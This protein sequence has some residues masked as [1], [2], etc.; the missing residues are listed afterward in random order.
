MHALKHAKCARD[1]LQWMA[2]IFVAPM[3]RRA[4]RRAARR[5]SKGR[6]RLMQAGAAYALEMSQWKTMR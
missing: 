2:N 5:L 4:A 1:S 3:N 6:A